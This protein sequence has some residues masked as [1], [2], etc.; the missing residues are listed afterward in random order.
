MKINW[1]KYLPLSHKYVGFLN[2]MALTSLLG[3]LSLGDKHEKNF[4]F[5]I[6]SQSYTTLPVASM[7][8]AFLM[9]FR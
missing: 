9:T 5:N 2:M 3:N 4:F 6:G 8:T 7:G 1:F